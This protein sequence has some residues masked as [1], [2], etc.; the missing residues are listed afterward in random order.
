M[1]GTAIVPAETARFEQA[2]DV[3]KWYG[4]GYKPFQI[5][6]KMNIDR[7]TVDEHIA[8]WK[9]AIRDTKFIRDR[10]EEHIAQMDEHFDELSKQLHYTLDAIDKNTTDAA[11]M[12][13]RTAAIKALAEITTKRIDAL[14]K[15][16]LLDAAD[17]GDEIADNERKMAQLL[18]ILREVTAHCEQ[19]G[20]EVRRR[21]ADID[22]K[23]HGVTPKSDDIV[24]VPNE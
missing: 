11:L 18:A 6:K 14:Q 17:L 15:A 23:S 2:D 24:V 4:K 12:G 19:C 8:E 13:Q 5:A 21:A 10:V 20:P 22:G 7:K 9:E 3:M 1:T 16:G